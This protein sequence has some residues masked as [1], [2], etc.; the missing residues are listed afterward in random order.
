MEADVP[1]YALRDPRPTAAEAP[2]TFFLPSAAEIAAVGE[3]D[4]VQLIFEYFHEIEKWGAERMWVT[5]KEAS[6][7][8]LVGLLDSSPYEPTSPL[9]AGDS[10]A[11][12]RHLIIDMIWENPKRAPKRLQNRGYWQRC[13][14]DKCVLD[15]Q[16]PVEFL[17]RG[18]PEPMLEGDTA[19]DSGWSI[20]GRRGKATD[21]EMDAREVVYVALGAVL[22]HD[23]SWVG[24]IDAPV[25]TELMRDFETNAYFE[26]GQTKLGRA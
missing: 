13:L 7:D 25:G 12:E 17:H 18:E 10:I 15:G 26:V 2:Y 24:W 8:C 14:A 4:L 21:A 5:V 22:N 19:P 6:Q 20:R 16:E 3:G 1:S 9:K 11:F 23:D